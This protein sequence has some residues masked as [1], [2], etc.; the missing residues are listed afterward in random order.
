[1]I[2]LWLQHWRTA[3][4]NAPFYL[5]I[6]SMCIFHSNTFTGPTATY[7][8]IPHRVRY[9]MTAESVSPCPCKTTA[10]QQG[11]LWTLMMEQLVPTLC[12]HLL[13]KGLRG[14]KEMPKRGKVEK[15]RS[16][17]TPSVGTRPRPSPQHPS[18]HT[19]SGA[20]CFLADLT[21]YTSTLFLNALSKQ[22][23]AL[24]EICISPS[25]SPDTQI[26]HFLTLFSDPSLSTP[27]LPAFS[28]LHL[29]Y[30]LP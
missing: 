18:F 28:Y 25:K 2:G 26:I 29:I 4:G 5:T 8:L 16:R 11:A 12:P 1:M 10:W 19:T 24:L 3:F 17:A 7:I 9:N 30:S 21:H 13:M 20:R 22:N 27:S 23:Q 14:G 15:E 6:K